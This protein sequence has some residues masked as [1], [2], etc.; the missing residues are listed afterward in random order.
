MIQF[1]RLL[2]YPLRMK[3]DYSLSHIT[4]SSQSFIRGKVNIKLLKIASII[5]AL[6]YPTFLYIKDTILCSLYMVQ[7][8]WSKKSIQVREDIQVR[9]LERKKKYDSVKSAIIN[10][11]LRQQ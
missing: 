2:S 1:H 3:W 5:L 11:T 10:A 4:Y 7:G 9:L 6:S 8:G